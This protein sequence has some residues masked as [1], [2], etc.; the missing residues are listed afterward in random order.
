MDFDVI[1][2]LNDQ[3]IIVGES[4]AIIIN[5]IK[6]LYTIKDSLSDKIFLSFL[7]KAAMDATNSTGKSL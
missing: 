3:I 7:A 6:F 1:I 4:G 5:L 2:M